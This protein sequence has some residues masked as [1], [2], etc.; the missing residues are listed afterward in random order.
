MAD[1]ETKL[2]QCFRI[3]TEDMDT[4]ISIME[5]PWNVKIDKLEKYL[6]NA[7]EDELIDWV[8]SL[9]IAV[10]DRGE[11]TRWTLSLAEMTQRLKLPQSIK[12][13]LTS[14]LEALHAAPWQSVEKHD[15]DMTSV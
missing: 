10:L 12:L 4:F 9:E 7:T 2:N 3:I 5:K 15:D 13:V 11:Q 1:F 6:Q 14:V 8:N